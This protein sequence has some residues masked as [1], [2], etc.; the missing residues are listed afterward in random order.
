MSYNFEKYLDTY[1]FSTK[2]P[3]N[4][5]TI[6][7]RPLTTNDMKKLLVYENQQEP[8]AGEEILDQIINET[9][10]TEGFDV[11]NLYIQDRYWIFIELRKATKGTKYSFPYTCDKCG[12]Q[13]VQNIDLDKLNVRELEPEK[14]EG[15][16]SILNDNVKL[17]M[18]IPT[19]QEQAEGYK[20][21]DKTLSNTE[22]QIEMILADLA[23]S[24]K[25]ISTSEG[26]ENPPIKDRM[27]F[28]ANLPGTEYDKLSNWYKSNDFGID[29]N[30]EISCPHCGKYVNTP[31]PLDNFFA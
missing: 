31:I 23:S 11:R 3:G 13:S 28:I 8:L 20:T 4:G 2:L 12:N 5:E 9:V 22:K 21:I 30:I 17:K 18:D 25:S 27:D 1:K 10:L 19:R 14:I 24:V 15:E 6:E 26:E 29:L 7:F 16:L